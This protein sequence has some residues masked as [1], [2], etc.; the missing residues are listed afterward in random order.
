M[1][2]SGE[3]MAEREGFS[4]IPYR[5]SHESNHLSSNFFLFFLLSE[6]SIF[7]PVSLVLS[8]ASKK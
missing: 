5:E 7:F 1:D 2:S 3:G 6:V 4:S 8:S